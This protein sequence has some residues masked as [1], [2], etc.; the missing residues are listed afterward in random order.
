V[1]RWV[2]VALVFLALDVLGAAG[3]RRR[4]RRATQS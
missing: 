3:L 1:F 2:L 4:R